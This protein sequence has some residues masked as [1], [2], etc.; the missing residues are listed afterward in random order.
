MTPTRLIKMVARVRLD[1]CQ[2]RLLEPWLSAR[3]LN[4][5]ITAFALLTPVNGVTLLSVRFSRSDLGFNP[6]S[7]I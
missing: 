4:E 5:P 2:Y 3:H 6:A 1:T 7:E